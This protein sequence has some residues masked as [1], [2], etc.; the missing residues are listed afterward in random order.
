[1][2]LEVLKSKS[3]IESARKE[4]G[5]RGISQIEKASSSG[6]RDLLQRAGLAKRRPA[7]GDYLKSW[8]VLETVKFLEAHA[9]K[10]AP[11]LDIGCYASEIIVSLHDAGFTNLTGVDLNPD[12]S[13]MPHGDSIRYTKGDF[14]DTPFPDASFQAITSISVIEHGYDAPKLTKEMARLLA[15][16]GYFVASFDYWPDKIDTG[17]TRFFDM[18]WLIFSRDAVADLI[19]EAEKVGLHP[20]G[21]LNFDAGDKAIAHGG[22]DYTFAWLALQK[23]G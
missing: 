21:R 2:S 13:L 16:G 17:A 4:L 7:I 3:Q 18:D 6:F 14:M 8:D 15:P 1:M 9:D 10:S 20:A 12:L 11:I 23:R 5:K 19:A 22:Y